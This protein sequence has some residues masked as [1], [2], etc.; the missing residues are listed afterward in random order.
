MPTTVLHPADTAGTASA[1]RSGEAVFLPPERMKR[2]QWNKIIGAAF[3]AAI[4]GGWLFIQ[5][6]NPT[7]RL[8]ASVLLLVTLWVTL[9]S[10]LSDALRMRGRQLAISDGVLRITTPSGEAFVR[11]AEVAAARWN[12]DDAAS[13]GMIFYDA[14]GR[15]LG[16]IDGYFLADQPEAR[17][18]LFWARQH[19]NIEFPI[20]WPE[21]AS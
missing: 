4:F 20:H 18:F 1:P 8:I 15:E 16:V 21:I 9:R 11:L 19:A 7:M 6:S 14:N 12:E 3:F 13:T 5:W 17:T 2:Y 10:I